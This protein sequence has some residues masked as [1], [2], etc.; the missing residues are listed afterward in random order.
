[1]TSKTY[2]QKLSRLIKMFELASDAVRVVSNNITLSADKE[3]AQAFQR[4]MD[5][6]LA[7]L[8]HE[9]RQDK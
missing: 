1:M 9:F 7:W 8:R 2:K 4:G 5:W 3:R 6:T